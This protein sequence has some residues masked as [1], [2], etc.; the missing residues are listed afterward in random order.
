[1]YVCMSVHNGF[2]HSLHTFWYVPLRMPLREG[3]EIEVED[4]EDIR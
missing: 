1:M 2:M 3:M 4:S